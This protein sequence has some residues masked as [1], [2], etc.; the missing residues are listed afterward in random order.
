M[1]VCI[2]PR[3]AKLHPLRRPR[4]WCAAIGLLFLIS[5]G[6]ALADKEVRVPKKGDPAITL[7]VPDSYD[8]D[9]GNDGGLLIGDKTGA[10]FMIG[11]RRSW[12]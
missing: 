4:A 7:Q 11:S 8:V 12:Q 5:A 1:M 10:A 9:S 3:T 6:A 2:I